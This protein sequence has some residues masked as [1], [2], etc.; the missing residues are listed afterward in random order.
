M[1][2]ITFVYYNGVLLYRTGNYIQSLVLDHDGRKYKKGN[3]YIHIYIYTHTYICD[4]VTILYSRNWYNA[5]NIIYFN[6][7]KTTLKK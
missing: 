2:T 7:K 5:V 6:K 3:I 1:Q 4:R